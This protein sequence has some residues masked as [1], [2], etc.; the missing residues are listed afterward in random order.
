[1]LKVSYTIWTK[2]YVR[3]GIWCQ[4]IISGFSLG[5]RLAH[6]WPMNV[7]LSVSHEDHEQHS[8][9]QHAQDKADCNC[10]QNTWNRRETS[11]KYVVDE[12]WKACRDVRATMAHHQGQKRKKISST[13]A[14]IPLVGKR[15][16]TTSQ[17]P[18]LGHV[19][20][21]F[22]GIREKGGKYWEKNET[23]RSGTCISAEEPLSSCSL[24]DLEEQKQKHSWDKCQVFSCL[25][26]VNYKGNS[27]D[28]GFVLRGLFNLQKCVEI[29]ETS[30][31]HQSTTSKTVWLF[32]S[33]C[34]NQRIFALAL[35]MKK[36]FLW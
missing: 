4:E 28:S 11:N 27:N 9:N 2:K 10:D 36:W 35:L 31:N 7:P 33:N 6:K 16:C 18:V 24:S 29:M 17:T 12:G 14:L 3:S 26:C 19:P 13:D 1:M 5:E 21:A 20:T 34:Q 15:E 8:A 23:Y 32:Q 30:T 25:G 22:V